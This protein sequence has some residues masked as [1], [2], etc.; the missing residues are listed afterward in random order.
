M[1]VAANAENH[2]VAGQVDLDR[3]MAIAHFRQQ[4]GGVLLI[5]DIHAMADSFGVPQFDGLADMKAQPIGRHE[6]R[7]KF[8]RMQRDV[9]AGVD[10]LRVVDHRHVQMVIGHR[11]VAVF[12]L[13]EIHGHHSRIG[14]RPARSRPS[15]A[16]KSALSGTPAA[17][18]R[19]SEPATG[20]RANRASAR[21]RACLCGSVPSDPRAFVIAETSC[22]KPAASSFF[23]VASK[24]SV[25]PT[26]FPSAAI[27]PP[28]ESAISSRYDSF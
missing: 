7:R 14:S 12:R 24:S 23:R 8:A 1:V 3:D 10:A 2:V 13:H 21:S 15:P 19:R 18:D 27:G 11:G 28:P 22:G 16:R 26:V 6:P 17:P 4:A 20:R 5:H 9:H 25:S